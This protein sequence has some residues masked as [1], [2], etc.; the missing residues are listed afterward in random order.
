ME[1]LP[2]LLFSAI[3][4]VVQ[5][6]AA[7]Y[8]TDARGAGALGL[9]TRRWHGGSA[10]AQLATEFPRAPAAR[11]ALAA[12]RV[13][14]GG[15][16][17]D[18]L[19]LAAWAR[20][21]AHYAR[22]DEVVL[23]VYALGAR[24]E[25]AEETKEAGAAGRRAWAPVAVRCDGAASFDDLARAAGAVLGGAGDALA[26]AASAAADARLDACLV[27]PAGVVLYD[28]KLF[29]AARA[30]ASRRRS[31]RGRRGVGRRR[32]QRSAHAAPR[33]RG[34]RGVLALGDAP[35]PPW[36]A[37][38]T[39]YGSMVAAAARYPD[40]AA[41]V[42][43]GFFEDEG[44]A[45]ADA[46][47]TY[48]ALLRGA[49]ALGAALGGVGAGDAVAV[50][51]RRCVELPIA[52][53]GVLSTS[54][55]YVPVDPDYPE[56]RRASMFDDA[57]PES[58]VS[59]TA[60]RAV[61]APAGY[62][63]RVVFVDELD[64][65]ASA[66]AAAPPG[67]APSDPVYVLFTSGTTG[68]PK[69]VVV[70]HLT[71]ARRVAWFER[72][73]GAGLRGGDR[74]DGGA[75]D[76]DDRRGAESRRRLGAARGVV[77]MKTPAFFGVSEWELFW[78]LTVGSTLAVLKADGE[79]D[80]TTRAVS[81][82]CGCTAAFFSPAQLGVLLEL[83][84]AAPLPRALLVNIYGPTE[85]DIT[86]WEAP[87]ARGAGAVA[88]TV[89]CV[90]IGRPVDHV[91]VVVLNYDG[92]DVAPAGV[93]GELAFV[94]DVAGGYL[95]RPEATAK[96]FSDDP[97]RALVRNAGD[98]CY[99]T[100]DVAKFGADG[101]LEFLGRVDHQV[102]L[103]GFRVELGEVDV[104]L[105][106]VPGVLG[107]ATL[108]HGKGTDA[109]LVAYARPGDLDVPSVL[110]ALRAKLP[111]Y[112]VP[113][114]IVA[115][116]DFPVTDRG[117]L[118]RKKLPEPTFGAGPD[119]DA[120]RD[121][122]T[123]S[124]LEAALRQLFADALSVD[125]AKVGFD[126]DFE[127]LGGNSLLAGRAT[128]AIRR[129]LAGAAKIKGTAM[130]SH[131]SVAKLAPV[132]A[133]LQIAAGFQPGDLASKTLLRRQSTVTQT[134]ASRAHSPT[135]F[136]PL[137]A[138]AAGATGILALR[139][140]DWPAWYGLW[141]LDLSLPKPVV[142]SIVTERLERSF[143]GTHLMTWYYRALGATIDGGALID[144][145]L[146][147]PPLAHVGA[148]ATVA[149]GAELDAHFI[150]DGALCRRPCGVG[151][152]GVAG[153]HAYVAPGR[154]VPPW[155]KAG[156][157]STTAAV[158]ATDL[159]TG[160]DP[161][162]AAFRE[163]RDA[164]LFWRSLL[165]VPLLY[166]LQ[167]LPYVPF[168]YVLEHVY[169]G[170]RSAVRGHP[171]VPKAPWLFWI[172]YP[173]L[174]RVGFHECYFVVVVLFKRLVVG[175][176]VEGTADATNKPLRRWL[177][178]RLVEAEAFEHCM[179]PWIA[180]DCAC[181]VLC[182]RYR[183]LGAKIGRRVHIDFFRCVE[184]DLVT[185]EDD[186]VFG[187]LVRIVPRDE[188]LE[189]T[190]GGAARRVVVRREG[191]VLDHCVL[192]PGAV[193]GERAVLGTFSLAAAEQLFAPGAVATGRAAGRAVVL[194]KRP[195]ADASA[196]VAATPLQ[197]LEVEARRRHHSLPWFL[198][199]N[200]A[201]SL[202]ALLVY[203]LRDVF[204]T[205]IIAT[206]YMLYWYDSWT[207]YYAYFACLPMLNLV[208]VFLHFLLVFL[209]KRFVL[210]GKYAVGDYGFYSPYHFAW[211]LMMTLLAPIYPL[212]HAFHGT[213]FAAYFY[214]LMGADVDDTSTLLG[215]A[216]E[217]D[218]LT[219]GPGASVGRL[220]DATCHTVENMVIK[221]APVK[222]GAR[223]DVRS[224]AVVM[225]GGT[226]SDGATLLQNSLTLKGEL[227]PPK[228]VWAGLPA[229]AVD[230][231]VLLVENDAPD[232]DAA[233]PLL[234]P[235]DAAAAAFL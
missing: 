196:K 27:A 213:V 53:Y 48:A 209:L 10:E 12:A 31:A 20:V 188:T 21:L 170:L 4:A 178:E 187:S 205:G 229:E 29:G 94:G 234:Q 63:G 15:C 70:P 219:V 217:F 137:A 163:R 129:T 111:H 139:Y 169:I 17:D 19:L 122:R 147:D 148:Y 142:Q 194:R 38:T 185:V 134:D 67:P 71:L 161:P 84:A 124:P 89:S 221:L 208:S 82:A 149:T 214:R 93:P 233:A 85:A 173:W 112:M 140:L 28:A 102:K 125:V 144:G 95:E 153:V 154:S 198:G 32:A 222:I 110:K 97:P 218:L 145:R 80:R 225:P 152:G 61:A 182:A 230:A 44:L 132:V 216:L 33:R 88:K 232:A 176:F 117:K 200:A 100:G 168:V 74:A 162:S 114:A 158:G 130:Y 78:P 223:A 181:E 143:H 201:N 54:A 199:W 231:D 197:K 155:A 45:G 105:G 13:D 99:K 47:V 8:C 43:P 75:R 166:C 184:Y 91:R 11:T 25:P 59:E 77:L 150:R 49:V 16:R 42:A 30:A 96:A 175:R 227:A 98:R 133:K 26:R 18:D 183:L 66:A 191:N 192:L 206:G 115:L 224:R 215:K 108:L 46:A 157:L 37:A 165:G 107:A 58:V 6:G 121:T 151:A 23:G 127:A 86:F 5:F 226:L 9:L 65:L 3:D 50:V 171:A 180:C 36:D 104:A 92:T 123:W 62:G 14:L 90:P 118:D 79:R 193:V 228:T 68:R 120:P 167:A 131:A 76:G 220:C 60:L 211:A 141:Y 119:D 146:L 7:V 2:L 172:C 22:C 113:S 195:D 207:G 81:G 39:V 64:L 174:W 41:L 177:F 24:R 35:S 210:I 126:G 212:L 1:A 138:Q 186:V 128:N 190:D 87:A 202:F 34:R 179:R 203:P 189:D 156:P 204:E 57:K 160:L 69:G 83:L 101:T 116:D 51:L 73:Y 40:D 159:A 136:W 109:K 164:Q 106:A 56:S 135:S 235:P 72:R 103:R 52:V 55:Y